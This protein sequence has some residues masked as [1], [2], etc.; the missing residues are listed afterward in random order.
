MLDEL[1]ELDVGLLVA[2]VG[3]VLVLVGVEELELELLEL[4][5]SLLAS[6]LTV[7]APWLRFRDSVVLMLDGRL[8]TPLVSAAEAL[9]AWPQLW[10]CTALETESS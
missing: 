1:L 2:V 8:V 9:L 6:S 7:L 4:L 3:A 5:Q 10:D